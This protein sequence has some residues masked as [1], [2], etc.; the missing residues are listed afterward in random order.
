MWCYWW[1]YRIEEIV[2]FFCVITLDILCSATEE[3]HT[4]GKDYQPVGF[5]GGSEVKHLPP[6]WEARVRSQGR[7]DLLE[8]EMATHSSI[9]AWRIPWT[10]EPGGLQS[11]GLQRVGHDCATSL[12]E[13]VTVVWD[14]GKARFKVLSL[15]LKKC[16]LGYMIPSTLIEVCLFLICLSYML[17]SASMLDYARWKCVRCWKHLHRCCIR[18]ITLF[19]QSFLS[20]VSNYTLIEWMTH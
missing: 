12:H 19:L 2:T 5:P 15:V 9:L 4:R 6:M 8:K 3:V 11:T 10:E 1:F 13:A 20:H 16:F 7:E 18:S 17:A 14:G